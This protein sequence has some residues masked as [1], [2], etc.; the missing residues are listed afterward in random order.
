MSKTI[1]PDYMINPKRKEEEEEKANQQISIA[2]AIAHREAE[3][4]KYCVVVRKI[5]VFIGHNL[6]ST[7]YLYVPVKQKGI[8]S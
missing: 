1:I 8:N 4:Y 6:S 5:L 7:S 2:E 3:I